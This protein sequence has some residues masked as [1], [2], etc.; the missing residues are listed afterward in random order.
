[1]RFKLGSNVGD[2]GGETGLRGSLFWLD[3]G[4]LLPQKQ[5]Q[6]VPLRGFQAGMKSSCFK[7]FSHRFHNLE[8]QDPR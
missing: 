3:D 6:V 2:V 7:D 5:L 4:L 8:K 1:M